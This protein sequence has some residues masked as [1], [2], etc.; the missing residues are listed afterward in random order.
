LSRE[1]ETNASF[2]FVA[3]AT[4]ILFLIA[5]VFLQPLLANTTVQ[6]LGLGQAARS[7]A[8]EINQGQS[9]AEVRFLARG[10][11]YNLFLTSTQC[12]LT[13]Q[14]R[15]NRGQAVLRM[16]LTGANPQPEVEPLE[17]LEGKVNYFMGSDPKG[18]RTD[19]PTYGKIRYRE[20]YPGIDLVYYG[21]QGQ[22]EYDFVL[23]PG[24]DP[25]AIRLHFDGA[26]ELELD[27]AGSLVVRL[28]GK[29]VKW[30]KPVIYQVDHDARSTVEGNYVLK[31]NR[32]V[33]FQLSA[34]DRSRPLVIDPVLLYSTF[35]GGSGL[36]RATAM[37][38]DRSGNVYI[39]GQT[40]SPNFPTHTPY[41]LAYA[42]NDVF[43]AKLNPTGA[44][45]IYSTYVGGSGDDFAA[46]IALDSSGNAYVT[47][48]TVSQNFPAVNAFQSSLSGNIGWSDAFLFKLGPAGSTLPYSTYFG[49]SDIEYANAIAVDSSGNAYITGATVSGPQFPKQSP[50]Q[51]NSGGGQDAFVAKFNPAAS[52]G[53]SLIY[54]SWLGGNDSEQGNA[55]AV[56]S[57]GNAYVAGD[58]FSLDFATSSFPLVNPLQP[59]YGGGEVDGFVAKIN[60]AGSAVVFATLLGG[61]DND[62][63]FGITL[64]ASNNVYVAGQTVSTDFRTTFNAQQPVIG[65]GLDFGTADAFV[66]KISSSGASILYSTYFGGSGDEAAYSV[67]V[68]NSGQIYLTGWTLSDFDFPVTTGADQYFSNGGASDAF[69]AKINPAAPGPSG[70]VYSTYL[71]G[72]GSDLGSGDAGN[73]ITVDTNGTF[74]VCGETDSSDLLTTSG[75]FQRTYGGGASDAFIASFSSPADLSVSILASTNTVL[76]GSNLTY[77]LQ[78]NNNGRS[79]FTGVF[80]TNAVPA[81]V[82]FISLA[83][84]G[85]T[86]VNNGGTIVCNV[87]TLTNN[88]TA[89]ATILVKA[90]NTTVL[91]ASPVV[92]ANEPD[93]NTDNNHPTLSTTVRGFA[94]LVVGQIDTPD[95]VF[96]TSNL[97]Y[98]ISVTNKGPWP[99]T[100]V[101][102]TQTFPPNATFVSATQDLFDNPDTNIIVFELTNGLA[103]NAFATVGVVVTP[104]VA[105]TIANQVSVS[106]FELDL[107]PGNNASSI[108]TTVT[109]I[110]EL[111]L[112][113]STSSASV[114]AGS[115]L[116]YT[117][118]VSNQGPSSA[119]GVVLTNRLPAGVTYLGAQGGSCVITGSVVTCSLGTLSP[120]A[121]TAVNLAVMTMI[122]G[123]LTNIS[124][125]RS[126]VMDPNLGNNTATNFNTVL[127]MADLTLAATDIP[128]PVLLNSNLVYT[129]NVTNRGPSLAAN[130]TLTNIL[131][132]KVNFLT[133][134]PSQGS[135]TRAGN[136]LTCSFG[137]IVSGGNARFTITVTATNS[138]SITNLATVTATVA[139]ANLANN[140]VAIPTRVNSPP[141]ISTITNQFGNEDTLI[142]P[143]AFTVGDDTST[144]SLILSASSSNSNLVTNARITFGG[145]AAS[146]TVSILPL[147]NQFGST[148][149]TISVTDA[150][151]A[152]TATNFLLAVIG[153]NDRPTL[154]PIGNITLF[155]NSV[156]QPVNLSG[157]TA[158]PTNEVQTLTV[159]ATSSQPSLVPNPTPNYTS[160]NTTGTLVVTHAPNAIGTSLIT[161]TVQDNGGTASCGQ[162]TVTQTFLVT[163]NASPSLKIARTNNNNVVFS[164]PT[165][166][167]GFN[168]ESR[169]NLS[170][171]TNW[172]N[173]ANVPVV[174][175]DQKV[176]T[177]SFTNGNNF[178]RLRKP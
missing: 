120:G 93:I 163:I 67:A 23:R 129:L 81:G 30:P 10:R 167:P 86:C 64:D 108:T 173:V 153:V 168:L 14:A 68:D 37:A 150:D 38:L 112:R 144:S 105:G 148:T 101:F 9:D 118:S 41:H 1:L 117:L 33:R 39:T 178:Y 172:F 122:D 141:T 140:S 19:I 63:V 143:I 79:T 102:L 82:Q 157:I 169:T 100:Q 15:T 43:V 2:R 88:A 11:G 119:T 24:A 77:T 103:V 75:A 171:P 156:A 27:A 175:G 177:N 70:L 94:D 91:V 90:T 107:N 54:S 13:L 110:A 84:S 111:V 158:G 85:M 76:V 78:V 46:G 29:S 125:V 65:G 22:L 18:W 4:V 53:N 58:V 3:I 99:A 106:G 62:Q 21:Q 45:L 104:T 56:D 60:S 51:N 146:R 5:P 49:G 121:A 95:P 34:Y 138:G 135:F 26:E 20:V 155:T 40:I 16:D 174:V 87:G 32:E 83:T 147:T 137:S 109:P 127:P 136:T 166:A 44:A 160:P 36:D 130:V 47:G 161:V 8:F 134:T 92:V 145:S 142:G 72:T 124:S 74:Y 66:T 89:S 133:A 35:L 159:S 170:N 97:T 7:M 57:S 48:Q 126:G 132:A 164:W 162:N 115:N 59:L 12:V 71:G 113:A 154:N 176:V 139:D 25:E 31:E 55:I 98:S 114:L 69:V 123:S 80:V 28:D 165:N 128:D 73:G 96:V 152:T 17:P 116:T 52:G 61:S 50:F 151:G 149:I 42:S 131:P 6:R